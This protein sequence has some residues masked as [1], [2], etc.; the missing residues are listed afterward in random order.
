MA[1]EDEGMEP[2]SYVWQVTFENS[3]IQLLFSIVRTNS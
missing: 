3:V 2:N 1:G